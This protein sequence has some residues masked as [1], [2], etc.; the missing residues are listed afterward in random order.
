MKEQIITVLATL[1]LSTSA[2]FVSLAA[3]P[4]TQQAQ[5]ITSYNQSQVKSLGN[6]EQQTDGRW[7]FKQF[8]GTYLTSSWIE[9]QTTAGVW[10]FV[11][12][13]GIML[14]SNTTPDGYTV[15]ANGI[16]RAT[17]SSSESHN[18]SK[19]SE[20]NTQ[21][22]SQGTQVT[23]GN[24]E[25]QQGPSQGTQDNTQ[26]NNGGNSNNNGNGGSSKKGDSDNIWD[27]IDVGH[28]S[29]YG[30]NAPKLNN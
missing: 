15:D 8:N 23:N 12:S 26:S 7:K 13:N 18:N 24:N 1:L 28:S 16:W 3:E 29:S 14:V 30:N 6:W 22:P 5:Q 10:Y 11:D 9:S 21:T 4:A 2:T 19:Q 27:Y 25:N 20:S 17:V